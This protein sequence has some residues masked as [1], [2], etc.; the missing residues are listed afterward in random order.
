[1]NVTESN[2]LHD[3]DVFSSD[4]HYCLLTQ[5]I[6]SRRLR[7]LMRMARNN[8]ELERIFEI[9]V[10]EFRRFLRETRVP[11]VWNLPIRGF[12]WLSDNARFTPPREVLTTL[13]YV[14]VMLVG[15]DVLKSRV[16]WS[17]WSQSGRTQT[18]NLMRPSYELDADMFRSASTADTQAAS[19][20]DEWLAAELKRAAES[21]ELSGVL[22]QRLS[23]GLDKLPL[24][25]IVARKV[26]QAINSDEVG[27]RANL[28]ESKAAIQDAMQKW[29]ASE[30]FKSIVSAAVQKSL[31][32]PK[33]PATSDTK[34]TATTV[35][36][37]EGP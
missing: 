3:P 20:V 10:A 4:V 13:A 23:D 9:K 1:M 27:Q 29:F 15:V 21:A 18:A 35:A 25:E 31:E 2:E 30:E 22:A 19:K 28:T 12:E 11:T 14:A 6:R 16:P 5:G 8:A 33:V 17:Q 32:S 34:P 7:E 36:I 26:E 24:D 37:G